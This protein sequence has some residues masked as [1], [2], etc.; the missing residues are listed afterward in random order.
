MNAKL[1]DSLS[2]YAGSER[3]EITF[4]YVECKHSLGGDVPKIY[5]ICKCLDK[6]DAAIKKGLSVF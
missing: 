6:G 2:L 4:Q 3:L 5:V 1:R